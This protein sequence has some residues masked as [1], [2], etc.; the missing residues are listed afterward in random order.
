MSKR[1]KQARD[2]APRKAGKHPG[3]ERLETDSTPLWSF[4]RL[5][6]GGPWC[7]SKIESGDIADVLS[8]MGFFETMSWTE[9][10]G[11]GCHPIAINRLHKNAQT[12]LQEINQDDIEELYS[13]RLSGRQRLWG[14]KHGRVV[15][16]LWW[17]PH[18]EVCPSPKKHT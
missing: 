12:R 13:F 18:H 1:S 6:V 7:W 14:I 17:D 5:D 9:L 3:R 10:A 15:T 8:K 11:D 4:Q 16:L 2:V